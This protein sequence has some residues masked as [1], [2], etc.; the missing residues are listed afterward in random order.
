MLNEKLINYLDKS[1]SKTLKKEIIITDINAVSGGD[2]NRACQLITTSGTFFLKMN[3]RDEFPDMFEKEREGLK[4]FQLFSDFKVPSLILNGVF[5]NTH[6]LVLEWLDLRTS[7]NW[8]LFGEILAQMHQQS[9]DSFGFSSNNYIGSLVQSNKKWDN[10]SVFYAQERLLPLFK[11][12]FD[13]GYFDKSDSQHLDRL[14]CTLADVYPTEK[15]SLLH[16]DLWSGNVG[17]HNDRPVIFDP[18]VYFGH[19]EMDLGMTLLFGGF[20]KEMYTSYMDVYPLDK[21]W[22]SRISLSQLYPLLVHTLLFGASYALRI[23]RIL[24]AF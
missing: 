19:R 18:A 23:K 9:S 1:L 13:I 11:R 16:G 20:P 5:Q 21:N 7:G 24:K 3:N 2:I 4:K 17:F 12:S 6:F 15:P 14:I 10:W 22:E 8:S